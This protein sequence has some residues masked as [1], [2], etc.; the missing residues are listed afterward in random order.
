MKSKLIVWNPVLITPPVGTNAPKLLSEEGCH[1]R[2]DG[3]HCPL[4]TY[5]GAFLWPFIFDEKERVNKAH[6]GD[7][8]S[9]LPV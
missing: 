3:Q 4:R 7:S 2:L 1:T 5:H 6:A 8:N 9:C